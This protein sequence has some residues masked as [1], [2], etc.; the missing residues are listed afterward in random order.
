MKKKLTALFLALVMCMTLGVPALAYDYSEQTEERTLVSVSTDV[1]QVQT[2]DGNIYNLEVTERIYQ[3]PHAG[4]GERS[5]IP[6][7]EIGKI[8][9][10][11]FRILNSEMLSEVVDYVN[12]SSEAKAEL[13]NVAATYISAALGT[14]LIM[15]L[16]LTAAMIGALAAINIIAGEDGFLVTVTMVYSAY[17]SQREGYY[18]YGWDFEDVSV[19]VF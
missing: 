17:Y 1:V 10:Y 14:N 2:S 18:L 4:M 11:D 8:R 13:A 16:N 9:E 7:E 15:G 19:S 6:L 3:I 12:L 5:Y